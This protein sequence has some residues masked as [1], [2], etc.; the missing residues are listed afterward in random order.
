MEPPGSKQNPI[1]PEAAEKILELELIRARAVRQQAQGRYRGFR[2]ASFVFIFFILLGTLV[3]L[4]YFFFLGGFDQAR[5]RNRSQ[6][7][8]APTASSDDR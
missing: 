2:T 6:S 7:S 3:A 5:E 1:D 4:Y 8:P